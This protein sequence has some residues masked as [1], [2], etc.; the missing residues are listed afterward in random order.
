MFLKP[1]LYNLHPSTLILPDLFFMLLIKIIIMEK[2]YKINFI[3]GICIH[4]E[5]TWRLIP[6]RFIRSCCIHGI[7]N[8]VMHAHDFV[9]RHY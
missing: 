3:H 6:G 5:T 4:S 7:H 2:S 8:Y 1:Q 9:V